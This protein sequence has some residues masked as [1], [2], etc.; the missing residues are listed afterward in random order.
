L[1]RV[2][3]VSIS[4]CN[5]YNYFSGEHLTCLLGCSTV[6]LYVVE[7]AERDPA[8]YGDGGLALTDVSQV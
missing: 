2:Y 3:T 1:K 4:A 6:R 5:K 8:I 7:M